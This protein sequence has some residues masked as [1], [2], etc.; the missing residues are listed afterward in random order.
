MTQNNFRFLS[1]S[2]LNLYFAEYFTCWSTGMR[3]GGE[4]ELSLVAG[5]VSVR[6]QGMDEASESA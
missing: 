2:A 6:K 1:D 3:T 5:G 4:R